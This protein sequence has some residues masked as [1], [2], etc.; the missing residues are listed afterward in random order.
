MERSPEKH[1]DQWELDALVQPL[2]RAGSE[3]ALLA[4][5]TIGAA[6]QHLLGCEACQQAVSRYRQL[7][8]ARCNV[9]LATASARPPCPTGEGIDWSEVASG[10][11]PEHKTRQLIVHAA[12][13][14]QCGPS[15][16]AATLVESEATPLEDAL[17]A[18]L[19][20]PSRPESIKGTAYEPSRWLMRCLVPAIALALVVS[21]VIA[22]PPSPKTSISGQQ[23]SQFAVQTHELHAQGRL[24]LD[25][26]TDSPEALNA[27]LRKKASFP[28]VLPTSPIPPAEAAPPYRLEGAQLVRLGRGNAAYIAYRMQTGPVGLMVTPASLAVAS[29]GKQVNI[30]QLAFH[31]NVV[32]KYRV[33]TWSVH[34]L[35]YALVSQDSDSTQSSCMVCHSA[36]KDRNLS[37]TPTPLVSNTNPLEPL[38]Q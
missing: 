33:V 26:H 5:A 22:N 21:V 1:L 23:L 28:L 8:R 16:R 38:L 4:S 31:Y 18:K 25:F 9:A 30:N 34:G 7:F 11:W 20:Q 6:E 15:L 24:A 14:D 13:C 2:S 37:Q 35:T 17:L 12:V 29:G 36:L 32:N 3:S 10:L 19:K 27:W